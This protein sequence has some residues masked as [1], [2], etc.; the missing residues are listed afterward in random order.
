MLFWKSAL[1]ALALITSAAP[2]VLAQDGRI[3]LS[4][5]PSFDCAK[6]RTATERLICSDADLARLDSELGA[7]FRKKKTQLPVADQ[8]A[9]VADEL[10]WIKDRV[11]RCG[12][13]G[14]DGAALE[15]LAIFKPCMANEIRER[16]A[17]LAQF[18]PTTVP[19]TATSE[20]S[21]LADGLNDFTLSPECAEAK[22]RADA[23]A[24]RSGPKDSDTLFPI[25]VDSEWRAW[26]VRHRPKALAEAQASMDKTFSTLAHCI[27]S[28]AHTLMV[29][30]ETAEAVAAAAF[31][32]C[33]NEVENA[34]RAIHYEN[35]LQ[36]WSYG[37]PPRPDR[38]RNVKLEQNLAVK[39]VPLVAARIM[40][41]RATVAGAP[42]QQHVASISGTAF[43]ISKEGTALTNNHVVEDCQQIHFHAADQSGIA[44]VVARD[45]ENDL[46]VLATD[47]HPASVANW[48]LSIRQGEDIVVYGFPLA[49]VL[50]A[51]GNVA[52]GNVTALA[53]L[54]NDSR[55]LQ[56]SAPV[57]PGNSG[58]PLLD[59]SGNV[60]GIVVA[61]LDALKI[62]ATIGDIPQ[63][64]NFAI[65]ASVAT[66]FLDAQRV[67]HAEDAGGP[68][69]STPDIAERANGL[70]VQVTC[71]R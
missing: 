11:T 59:R 23:E 6:A 50:A 37:P 29:S 68:P 51:S 21:A 30:N 53:G 54:G 49:G 63:N 35:Q 57:Q 1:G 44:R 3:A 47:F 39:L 62:A 14:K 43:F 10:A 69:L 26:I 40:Q 56:I 13:A 66:A 65:K 61:K 25:C 28:E 12:L 48:R 32:L 24:N 16:I 19:A 20:P 60:V 34:T 8:S 5:K 46:A 55:Y 17:F 58:G 7:A 2:P 27:Y 22:R 9:L 70:A 42:P 15:L 71:V 67:V 64:I 38:S 45:R 18:H 52:V 33:Q 36:L 31:A 4:D 41:D